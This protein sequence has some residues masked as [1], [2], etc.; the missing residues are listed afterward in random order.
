MKIK[1]TALI[2]LSFILVL[3]IGIACDNNHSRGG[4]DMPNHVTFEYL[5]GKKISG[6]VSR[7]FPDGT[8]LVTPDVV[9]KEWEAQNPGQVAPSYFHV[10]PRAFLLSDSR[11]GKEYRIHEEEILSLPNSEWRNLPANLSIK[12]CDFYYRALQEK[13]PY[14]KLLMCTLFSRQ[15]KTL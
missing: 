15:F 8:L 2:A 5:P 9:P 1:I 7:V 6:T 4:E 14:T 3:M 10:D 12:G 11:I 13:N